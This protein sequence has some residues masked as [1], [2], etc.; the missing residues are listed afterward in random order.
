MDNHTQMREK[1]RD[2]NNAGDAFPLYTFA[3][4]VL[5]ELDRAE[6]SAKL[7]WHEA[8]STGRRDTLRELAQ[9]LEELL[10]G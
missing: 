5:D 7:N 1:L 3:L 10:N 2:A 8:D 4:H 6:R 9:K